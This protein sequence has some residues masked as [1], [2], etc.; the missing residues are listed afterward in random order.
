VWLPYI[1]DILTFINLFLFHRW[2]SFFNSSLTRI[3]PPG[4]KTKHKLKHPLS[5]VCLFHHRTQTAQVLQPWLFFQVWFSEATIAVNSIAETCKSRCW[6]P[7]CSSQLLQMSHTSD[8]FWWWY[9]TEPTSGRLTS[10]Y[11]LM[12]FNY[13]SFSKCLIPRID[14]D[15]GANFA[16]WLQLIIGQYLEEPAASSKLA[17]GM[18]KKQP[19]AI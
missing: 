18:G 7:H 5:T 6:K 1:K 13:N 2:I 14:S 10:T 9:P 11:S 4:R 15:D 8:R 19:D 16:D 12:Q 17:G 3:S